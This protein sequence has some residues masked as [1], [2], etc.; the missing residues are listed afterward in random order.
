MALVEKVIR[1]LGYRPGARKLSNQ[2]LFISFG[3]KQVS[4]SPLDIYRELVATRPGLKLIWAVRSE[5]QQVPVDATKV[6]VGTSEWFTALAKSKYLVSNN[7]LPMY[8]RKSPGQIY[9][10][11][12]HGTPLKKIGKDI[13]KNLLTP[14]YNLAMK[15]EAG[16]WDYLISPNEF[17]SEIFPRAFEFRGRLLETGYPR[18]DRLTSGHANARETVREQ[19]GVAAGETVVLYAPTWRDDAIDEKGG[20]ATVNKLES[21]SLPKGIRLL[22]RGHTNTLASERNLDPSVIDVTTY[23][24]ITDL[25]LAAD[26]LVTD[27][28]SV[29]FDFSV[30][31]KPILF[32]CPDLADYESTRGF[33]FDFSAA[34][35]G[36]ILKSSKEVATALQDLDK[37][38]KNY[39]EKYSKWRTKFNRLEDG[40]AASRV[41]AAV[42][43]A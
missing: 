36:P 5:E 4:D 35:P 14:L 11:T 6:V 7:N 31:G 22:Y 8:F 13:K 21:A 24:D 29:M 34:A 40:K 25:Y 27:Y 42:F 17:S 33:Y 41:V 18:N 26:V 23:P 37:I 2:A 38:A 16:F 1:R 9:L 20:W 10:Q 43:H 12:W 19:L 32:L 28:S 39:R 3:G 30:T 15:R